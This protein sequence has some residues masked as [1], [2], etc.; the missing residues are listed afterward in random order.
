MMAYDAANG[1]MV[2]FG[3]GGSRNY[4]AD[5]W[6]WNGATWTEQHPAVSP[7]ARAKAGMTY[8]A[9]AR[10][11]VLFG[12]DGGRGLGDHPL[13]DTWTWNGTTWTEQHPAVS[14][15]A[16]YGGT[17]AY[18]AATRNVVLFGGEN[19][20]LLADTWT[21]NGVTWTEQHPAVSPA[22]RFAEAMAYDATAHTGVIFGGVYIHGFLN[23][24]WT[25]R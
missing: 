20:N 22:P 25:W 5:T 17:M 14:P 7:P 23:E 10:T 21:W 13:N 8:D 2:L 11:I 3:G 12:G 6:T 9:A 19:S 1:T 4:L 24:T 16:R 15:A 18:D